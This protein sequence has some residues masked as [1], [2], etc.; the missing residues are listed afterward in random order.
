MVGEEEN[1]AVLVLAPGFQ[2]NRGSNEAPQ[3]SVARAV[4]ITGSAFDIPGSYRSETKTKLKPQSSFFAN[5]K[6]IIACYQ[7]QRHQTSFRALASRVM[8][9]DPLPL[10]SERSG[11]CLSFGMLPVFRL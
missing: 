9:T 4:S 7:N 3:A 11:P 1:E 8:E 5:N 2:G 6:Q 10:L